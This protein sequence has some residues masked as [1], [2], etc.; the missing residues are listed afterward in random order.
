MTITINLKIRY[1]NYFS[2]RMHSV[3]PK[4]REILLS[5]SHSLHDSSSLNYGFLFEN[6]I[7]PSSAYSSLQSEFMLMNISLT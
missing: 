5:I 4:C 3:L 6:I 2:K 1:G 7:V